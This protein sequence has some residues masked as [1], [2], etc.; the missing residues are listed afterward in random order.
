MPVFVPFFRGFLTKNFL[1]TVPI[2]RY[3]P[4]ECVH[5]IFY[6][7]IY[8]NLYVYAVLSCIS[9]SVMEDANIAK[10]IMIL[11][12]WWAAGKIV[13][14]CTENAVKGPLQNGKLSV[15]S[16]TCNSY[17]SMCILRLCTFCRLYGY[18]MSS[19]S[20]FCVLL[21]LECQYQVTTPFLLPL[22]ASR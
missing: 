3:E 14:E 2:G 6:M 1:R 20:K 22:S 11:L 21:V 5:V 17:T 4:R 13:H 8:I 15:F 19:K 12:I 9:V 16:H 10:S 7:Y 18:I